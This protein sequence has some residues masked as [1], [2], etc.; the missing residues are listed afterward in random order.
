MSEQSDLC[1]ALDS[2]EEDTIE[3]L[4]TS[5]VR[6]AK[7][8]IL[9]S[10]EKLTKLRNNTNCRRSEEMEKLWKKLGRLRKTGGAV[11]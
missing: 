10:K 3:T 7:P 1:Q 5:I 4:Q 6:G 9:I 8:N 11:I 2:V